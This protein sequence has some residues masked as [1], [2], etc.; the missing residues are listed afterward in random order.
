MGSQEENTEDEK[1]ES[2]K[3]A[4]C[5]G[6]GCSDYSELQVRKAFS[7]D[8]PSV[9]LGKELQGWGRRRA[10]LQLVQGT[11]EGPLDFSAF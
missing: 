11:G 6:S 10:S 7:G 8:L 5:Q 3:A 4:K 1:F 9:Q 2:Q